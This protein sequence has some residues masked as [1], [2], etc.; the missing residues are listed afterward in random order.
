MGRV[1]VTQAEE[2]WLLEG[3]VA[4][5]AECAVDKFKSE[6]VR[7]F[8]ADVRRFVGENGGVLSKFAGDA[9]RWR[10]IGFVAWRE[11][12]GG[13]AV[14]AASVARDLAACRN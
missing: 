7:A 14:S 1:R 8:R 11:I 10:A 4:A 5:L 3:Y 2:Q 12:S 9:S 6:I 13:T